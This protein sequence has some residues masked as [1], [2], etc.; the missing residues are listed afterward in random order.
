MN[1][2]EIDE[3]LKATCKQDFQGVFSTDTLPSHPKLF[4]CNTDPSTKPGE[5]W[6]AIYVSKDG[7][8][9]YFDSFG[10][11]PEKHFIDYL[12]EHCRN[13]IYN[14]R[15]LQSIISSF[16]G[17]YCC[18]Y[19]MYRCR[20]FDLNKVVNLFTTDTAFNDSI[21]HAFVCNKS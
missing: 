6:I 16:C 4:V 5:H 20:G 21:V 14:K 12:N 18:L 3:L 11:Q 1:T 9:E 10:R 17:Y 13:W 2:K 8:G 7:R 15:Q 19:C